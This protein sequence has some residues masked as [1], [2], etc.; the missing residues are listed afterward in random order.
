LGLYVKNI[1]DKNDLIE[2]MSSQLREVNKANDSAETA[3]Y[4]DNL[5]SSVI[6]TD[7]DWQE[8]KKLFEKAFPDFFHH[9][10]A[11]YPGLTPAEVRL[12]ALEKLQLPT[13]DMANMLGISADSIKKSRY[14]LRKKFPGSTMLNIREH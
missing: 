6:L 13:K 2:K 7:N 14:R 11:Q 5:Q 4:V 1:Q 12:L 9:L 3:G 10:T 8:F